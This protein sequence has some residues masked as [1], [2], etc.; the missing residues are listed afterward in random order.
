[1]PACLDMSV[2]SDRGLGQLLTVNLDYKQ[3]SELFTPIPLHADRSRQNVGDH[4]DGRMQPTTQ[5]FLEAH[6]RRFLYK[7]WVGAKYFSVYIFSLK[8]RRSPTPP[9]PENRAFCQLSWRGNQVVQLWLQDAPVCRQHRRKPPVKDNDKG[10]R[11]E[12]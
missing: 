7:I 9:P 3:R 4:C 12:Q 10:S 8:P 6:K 11:C 5:R 1:M 2:S